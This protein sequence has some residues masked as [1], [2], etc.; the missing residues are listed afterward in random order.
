MPRSKGQTPSR[1]KRD[2]RIKGSD[3]L[4]SVTGERDQREIKGSE[5]K[6]SDSLISVTGAG[7]PGI[8]QR[9]GGRSFTGLRNLA[10]PARQERFRISERLGRVQRTTPDRTSR[11]VDLKTHFCS[12]TANH[13]GIPRS[14][15]NSIYL[16]P[17][18]KCTVSDHPT[19]PRHN[20][21]RHVARKVTAT[22][23]PGAARAVANRA[24]SPRKTPGNCCMLAVMSPPTCNPY[25]RGNLP[26]HIQM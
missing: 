22:G 3:S 16:C 25:C 10:F 24:G 1:S 13:Q 26:H 12:C 5:I 17:R 8:S 21:L 6:G 23:C 15:W 11:M 20:V 14:L 9:V 19:Y 18:H 7:A 4:I 2:Q